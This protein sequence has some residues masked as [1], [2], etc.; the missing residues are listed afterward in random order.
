[1]KRRSINKK[2][3]KKIIGASGKLIQE[4][5]KKYNIYVKFMNEEEDGCNVMMKTPR[6]N[7]DG[8]EK[9]KEEIFGIASIKYKKQNG[10]MDSLFQPSEIGIR[11][12]GYNYTITA[13]KI[14]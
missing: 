3:H 14:N 10:E 5:M 13:D 4:I 2:Y 8:L 6:K 11:R 12:I 9:I 7:I 1:M